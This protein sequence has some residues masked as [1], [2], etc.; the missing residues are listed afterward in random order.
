M[1]ILNT[2]DKPDLDHSNS[3]KNLPDNRS[4][5][6]DIVSEYNDTIHPIGSYGQQ[7]MNT[8]ESQGSRKKEMKRA[9]ATLTH[10]NK[11]QLRSA[12][13]RQRLYDA[14]AASGIEPPHRPLSAPQYTTHTYTIIHIHVV[15]LNVMQYSIISDEHISLYDM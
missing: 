8:V 14:C 4:R 7:K 6:E 3:I 1:L 5:D 11:D 10:W 12:K 13:R 2:N 9:A 15:N